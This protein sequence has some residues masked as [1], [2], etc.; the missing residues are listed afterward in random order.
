M[1]YETKMYLVEKYSFHTEIPCGSEIASID[2]CKCGGPVGELIGRA[3]KKTGKPTFA[4]YPRNPDR[5]EEVV[6]LLRTIR[7]TDTGLSAN[8]LQ[9]LADDIEDGKITTDK[10]GDYLGVIDPDEMIAALEESLKV[11]DYRRYRW[12]LALLRDVRR[13]MPNLVVVTYGH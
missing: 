7:P 12:A 13:D 5:Q 3:I 2:L 10:Y 11:D 9:K 8:G 1:G 6:A 4:L